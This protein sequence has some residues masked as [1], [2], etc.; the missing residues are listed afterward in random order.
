MT[1][2]TLNR[3]SGAY[4]V[5]DASALDVYEDGFDIHHPEGS[6]MLWTYFPFDTFALVTCSGDDLISLLEF[7]NGRDDAAIPCTVAV[8]DPYVFILRHKTGTVL[9]YQMNTLRV[10][11]VYER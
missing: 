9:N 7:N 6:E 3:R 4:N 5:Y 11:S 2:K 8:G 10:A 1:I